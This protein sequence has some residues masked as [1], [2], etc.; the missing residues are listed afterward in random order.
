ML[1]SCYLILL[2]LFLSNSVIAQTPQYPIV[3]GFGG[4]YEIE[5]V[6][7]IVNNDEIKIVID[8]KS[9]S[10]D[11]KALNP[12]LNNVARLMNL[13]ILNGTPKNRLKVVVV[14]HGLATQSLLTNNGYKK[15]NGVDNPNL[16]LIKALKAAGAEIRI[17]GQSL[18]GRGFTQDE[19]NSEVQIRLSMLT[20]VSARIIE[21]YHLLVFN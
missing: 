10:A 8:L 15:K 2:S 16:A 4:I 13:H 7:P 18:I 14:G 9:A 20:E 19:V 6:E 5:G 17:C 21:G 12:G 1:K 3:Q 11:K